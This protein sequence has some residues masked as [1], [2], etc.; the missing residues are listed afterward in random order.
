[1]SAK[2]DVKT[3]SHFTRSCRSVNSIECCKTD[4]KM[5]II[6]TKIEESRD[7]NIFKL[8]NLI[9]QVCSHIDPVFLRKPDL[10]TKTD[11]SKT[12]MYNKRSS[13]PT[14]YRLL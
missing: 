14:C 6:A 9:S 13:W 8:E 1:M 4:N 12:G 7:T 2:I 3:R 10:G 11:I 5:E